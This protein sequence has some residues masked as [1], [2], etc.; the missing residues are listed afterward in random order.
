MS[1]GVELLAANVI[2]PEGGS[3][4]VFTTSTT[5]V[6]TTLSN[7]A[8]LGTLALEG[9]YL[10]VYADGGD[11][12]CFFKST[13]A[14]SAA[15]GTISKTS[16]AGTDRS[17]LIP[18]GQERHFRLTKD[19]TGWKTRMYHVCSAAAKK[20]RIYPSSARVSNETPRR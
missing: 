18:N 7:T 17:W 5:D 8:V 12:Y 10:T 11:V 1:G 4:A 19:T 14:D 16:V 9:N 15:A 3:I 2:C 6:I 13:G 20:I